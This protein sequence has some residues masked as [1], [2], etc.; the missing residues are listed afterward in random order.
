LR[1]VSEPAAVTV[2]GRPAVVTPDNHFTA[3]AALGAGTN[4]VTVTATDPS[5]NVGTR[6][7]EVDSLGTGR[8]FTYDANGNMTSDGTWTFEWDARD[9][10]VAVTV[11][12][13]RSDF[14]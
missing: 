12:T 6:Q 14:A 4:T 11:G 9:Q 2:Q 7:Y 10:L 3:S 13:H 5:G 1:T 8:T